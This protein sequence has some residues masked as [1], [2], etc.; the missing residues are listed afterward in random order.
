MNFKPAYTITPV[1]VGRIEQI[2]AL[3]EKIL[4]AAVNVAWIPAMQFDAKARNT[5]C[6]TA[7][8]GNPLTLEQVRAVE[9]GIDIPVAERAKREVLNYLAGL[10]HIEQRSGIEVV[11]H[12]DLFELHGIIAGGGVM[13]QGDAGKYR[14]INVRVGNHFPPSHQD[15][16]VLMF[17]LLEWWNK[18][19]PELS[20]VISSAILHYRFEEIH[21]F[22]DGNG[23]MGRALALWDLYRR[24]FDTQ[25]IF[26]VDEYYWED[27]PRYYQE[28]SSV[29]SGDGEL[30]SWIEYCAEGLLQTLQRA[31]DRVQ[32]YSAMTIAP[33]LT[34]RPRQEQ[35]LAL[36]QERGRM[37]PS[38]IWAVL[39]ISRQGALKLMQPLLD[40][41]L[42][43]REGTRKSGYYRLNS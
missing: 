42:I 15:V 8:E 32:K 33:Q 20:P 40:A 31:W 27:R 30:S 21:P 35:L 16:S 23:R 18:A 14:T 13:D 3:R 6:S 26:S 38:E 9:K 25:H 22:A 11:R 12:E 37:A 7:I 4:G 1:L 17:D 29:Q 10:R 41:E 19:A 2:A 43:V 5:H 36:L 39:G 24:G 34:L 28:L